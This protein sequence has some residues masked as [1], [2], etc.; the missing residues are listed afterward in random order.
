MSMSN[1]IFPLPCNPKHFVRATSRN[2]HCIQIS[3]SIASLRCYRTLV[4]TTVKPARNRARTIMPAKYSHV[5]KRIKSKNENSSN[6]SSNNNGQ[7]HRKSNSHVDRTF[8]KAVTAT[9]TVASE[10]E[11]VISRILLLR[12]EQDIGRLYSTHLHNIALSY[13]PK[14]IVKCTELTSPG[15]VA[16]NAGSDDIKDFFRGAIAMDLRQAGERV[17][18]KSVLWSYI[19]LRHFALSNNVF[20]CQ[21]R[22]LKSIHLL[23]HFQALKAHL[24]VLEAM[25]IAS[26]SKPTNLPSFEESLLSLENELSKTECTGS[27]WEDWRQKVRIGYENLIHTLWQVAREFDVRGYGVTLREKLTTKWCDCGC[28]TDHLGEICERTVREEEEDSKIRSGKEREWDG[29][30]S[31][32]YGWQTEEEEDIWEGDL[33]YGGL[34]PDECD[35]Y[36]EMTVAEL[37]EWRYIKAERAKEQGNKAF[38]RGDYETAIKQYSTAY[39]IEPELPYYQLNIA[40]AYLKLSNWAEAEKACNVALSQQRSCKG[41]W[42]RAKARRMQGRI[43]EAVKDLRMVLRLQPGNEDVLEELTSI[44]PTVVEQ[45]TPPRSSDNSPE[46]HD[47]QYFR[48]QDRSSGPSSRNNISPSSGASGSGS[49]STQ[50]KTQNCLKEP[51][52]FIPSEADKR[53]LRFVPLTLQLEFPITKKTG[54]TGAGGKSKDKTTALDVRSEAYTYPTWEQCKIHLCK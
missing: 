45:L 47:I 29:R 21:R 49:T 28:S 27:V 1:F 14:L 26:F 18:A 53:R 42:R 2:L 46:R 13:L 31:G 48:S 50:T 44:I 38:R 40:A 43:I 11:R 32:I 23:P 12:Y 7:S 39:S 30:G 16:V 8:V 34:E 15:W 25:P 36:S 10:L 51:L 4:P 37:I 54:R 9:M 20:V 5:K 24:D 17:A 3:T 52:P 19:A 6:T 33:D 41:Y 22:G 35:G